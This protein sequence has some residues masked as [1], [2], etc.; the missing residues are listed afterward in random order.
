MHLRLGS[1]LCDPTYGYFVSAKGSN[2][3]LLPF[4]AVWCHWRYISK[5]SISLK[6]VFCQFSIE[7]RVSEPKL[8]SASD[9]TYQTRTRLHCDLPDWPYMTKYPFLPNEHFISPKNCTPTKNMQKLLFYKKLL[10]IF[11]QFSKLWSF[12]WIRPL[13]SQIWLVKGRPYGLGPGSKVCWYM[14]NLYRSKVYLVL[15]VWQCV[16]R[17]Q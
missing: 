7:V 8:F 10:C 6:Y 5:L 3:F 2:V 9:A 15:I 17:L 16:Q 11:F 4:D 12:I 1:K 14:C 13:R